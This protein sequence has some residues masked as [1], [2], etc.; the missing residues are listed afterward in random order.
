[1]TQPI[2]L[3]TSWNGP[4]SNIEALLNQHRSFGFRR[5]EAYMHFSP[6]ELVE[7]S[8]AARARDME[9]GSLHSPCPVPMN[10]QGE[11]SRWTDGLAS[12]DANEREF[13]VSAIKR[14]IDAAAEVGAQAIV[15]HL[16]NTGVTSRQPLVFDAVSRTG[17]NSAE[18][19]R[20]RDAAWAEREARKGAHLEAA[21]QSIR[22]LGEHAAGTGVRIGVE[23][24]D[25]YHEIPSLDEF[26]LVFEA[27]AG[28]PVGYWHDAG[29]GAKL[30]Y[31]GFAEHEEYLRRYGDR[32]VGMHVHDTLGARDHLAPGMGTTDFDML[33]RYLGPNVLKTMELTPSVTPAQI[34]AGLEF[35]ERDERFGV[36]EGILIEL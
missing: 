11:R 24:R 23:C 31:G 21:L 4:G 22:A 20:L 8:S 10:A 6:K 25:G 17:R 9:I 12:T 33:A 19:A 14:S 5:L 7:L 26:S 35:L 3:S 28:L 16:G 36:R 1:M 30:E 13:A 29:H 27:T 18:H 34:S 15:V 2:G 32:L